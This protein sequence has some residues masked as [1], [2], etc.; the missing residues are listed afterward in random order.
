MTSHPTSFDDGLIALQTISI[1]LGHPVLYEDLQ[2]QHKSGH[3]QDPVMEVV[4]AARSLGLKAK[5]TVIKPRNLAY[6]PCPFIAIDR[7]SRFF[8]VARIDEAECLIQE[9]EML[10]VTLTLEELMDKWRG[11]AIL[12][13]TRERLTGEKRRFDIKWFLPAIVKYKGILSEV[14]LASFFLQLIALAT[15][16]FFQVIIDKVVVHGALTTL[17][18]LA[19]GLVAILTINVILEWLRIYAFSHTAYRIDIELGTRLFRHLM[20]LPIAYFESRQAGQTVARVQELEN[21]REFLTGNAMTLVLDLLFI[22]VFFVVMWTYSPTLTLIVL[23]TIPLYMLISVFIT[24]PLRRRIEERF[25][26]G[27]AEYSFLVETV[28]SADMLK[29]MAV[30]PERRTRWERVLAAY[31]KSSFNVIKLGAT[32][33]QAIDWIGKLTTVAIIWYG[34]H[35]VLAGE[36]TIGMLVAFNI[37]AG[38]VI[39]PILRLSQLWQDFQQFRISIDRLGDILNAE[40][41]LEYD[42]TRP[43]P[44]T[45]DGDVSLQ[46]VRFR[47]H[48]DRQD[49]I[50]GVNLNIPA[51]QII[52]I[53][54]RSGSGKSTLARM[55][56]RLYV[57]TSGR[58]LIDGLDINLLNPAWLRRQI[59]VVPQENLL[60]NVTV[61]D[62]ISLTA[63]GA[64]MDTVIRAAQLAGADEFITEL[65][66]GY[67]TM[68]A[69]RGTS[70]SGGQRQRIAIAR[71]LV[72]NPRILIFDEATSAL[73]Y[74]SERI[75][76]QNMRAICADRTVVII[77]HRLS[78]VRIADRI[79][80]MEDGNIVEDGTH[81]QLLS[82]GGRYAALYRNQLEPVS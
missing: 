54:G 53:V 13:T 63:P 58:I 50:T 69:E 35:L 52:G 37:F 17:N 49:V 80:A 29:S 28:T 31:V 79:I 74:E 3:D 7:D 11:D 38:H 10:P 40:P 33:S 19:I 75:I 56:Q 67:N 15:P 62:N 45:L 12:V 20:Q 39:D 65:P 77:A 60:L 16:I 8:I 76:Q 61:R 42:E 44:A 70:L 24:P 47:Y 22:V 2:H 55:M 34:V 78:A 30:E 36:L 82:Q 5:A 6:T 51:G 59:G 43:A 26:R 1:I 73:D 57:P 72:A 32:G 64:P 66:H 81:D 18:T 48:P 46:H 25:A 23:A 4:R 71:A 14:L 21:I 68:I 27:A 41:E 9:G